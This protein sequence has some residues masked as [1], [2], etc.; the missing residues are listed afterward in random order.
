MLDIK[1]LGSY[2]QDTTTPSVP[3]N[4]TTKPD[5]KRSQKRLIKKGRIDIEYLQQVE[6]ERLSFPKSSS[7]A[8]NST[9][10]LDDMIESMVQ[11][12]RHGNKKRADEMKMYQ[13]IDDFKKTKEIFISQQPNP[14][15]NHMPT[16]G[17]SSK[18]DLDWKRYRE[19]KLKILLDDIESKKWEQ[20]RRR[21]TIIRLKTELG[22]VRKSI[23]CLNNKLK[24]VDLKRIE[25]YKTA[26]EFLGQKEEM[27]S[28]Y[29]EY[30]SFKTHVK[31]L[32]RK[33]DV[34]EIKYA[35]DAQV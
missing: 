20:I 32:A 31:E 5:R 24:N 10:E 27:N 18:R 8:S 28:I 2:N 12:I 4:S 3:I 33:G 29:N 21:A 22:Q 25:A 13:E 26:Y 11:R 9:Q 34:V 19:H 23:S 1:Y 35:C 30:Q 14:Q 15:S 7:M 6:E 17:R 16:R